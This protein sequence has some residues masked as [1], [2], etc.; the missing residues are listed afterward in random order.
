MTEVSA[1]EVSSVLVV[2]ATIYLDVEVC[3]I[4]G[5]YAFIY[6]AKGENWDEL[7]ADISLYREGA[8]VGFLL[9][10]EDADGKPKLCLI[11]LY[12]MLHGPHYD[13]EAQAIYTCAMDIPVRQVTVTVQVDNAWIYVTSGLNKV[14]DTTAVDAAF[15][16]D[17]LFARQTPLKSASSTYCVKTLQMVFF[18]RKLTPVLLMGV[19]FTP[20]GL[21]DTFPAHQ[22]ST[23]TKGLLS[24]N[25]MDMIMSSGKHRQPRRDRLPV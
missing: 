11:T 14:K 19:S 16:D 3:P 7:L 8:G 12:G 10:F 2:T 6:R 18:P 21:G 1:K 17:S 9:Y 24:A 22:D 15:C 25:S 23:D 5:V 20:G 4:R 13:G